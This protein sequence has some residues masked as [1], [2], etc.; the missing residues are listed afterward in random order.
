MNI[1]GLPGIALDV[2]N[3]AENKQAQFPTHTNF[4]LQPVNT[5]TTILNMSDG[6]KWKQKFSRKGE[7]A[8]ELGDGRRG[9]MCVGGADI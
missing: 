6:D 7:R 5:E 8:D 3:T 4:T 1:Y 2:G 9:G